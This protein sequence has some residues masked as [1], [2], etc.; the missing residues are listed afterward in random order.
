MKEIIES[1]VSPN[2]RNSG[3]NTP[4]TRCATPGE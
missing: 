1:G 2:G 4:L 3:L